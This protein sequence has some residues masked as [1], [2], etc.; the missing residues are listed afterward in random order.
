MQKL[1]TESNND[2]NTLRTLMS[3]YSSLSLEE[4]QTYAQSSYVK[5]FNYSLQSSVSKGDGIEPYSED[6]ITETTDSAQGTESNEQN[7]TGNQQFGPGAGFGRMGQQG[8][9]TIIGY[10]SEAAMSNFVNG[11][12][13]N[14]FV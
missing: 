4:M 6:E 1:Q 11:T 5:A 14:N 2:R 10:S 12:N 9:F 8:D 3:Q 13:R 7:K